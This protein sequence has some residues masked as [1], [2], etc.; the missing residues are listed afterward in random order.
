MT[1]LQAFM[2]ARMLSSKYKR[3]RE[4]KQIAEQERLRR[5]KRERQQRENEAKLKKVGQ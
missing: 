5:L 1:R 2:K 3:M 4:E